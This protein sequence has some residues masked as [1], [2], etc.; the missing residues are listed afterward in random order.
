M[1]IVDVWN[2][3]EKDFF[4]KGVFVY[5]MIEKIYDGE[6]KGLFL[7]CLNLIVLNLNVNFVKKV[8]EKFEF[9]VVVDMFELEMVKLVNLILL[10][11]F[12]L[13]DEGIMINV[14]GRVIL[15]EVS[16]LCGGE[17]KYDWEILCEIVKVLGKEE[18]FLFLLV[19]EIFNE[20]WIVSKGGIVDYSGIM[21]EWLWEEK[22]I[23]WLCRSL[24]DKGI[25]CLF[26]MCFV[27]SD[28]K[29]MM[30]FVLN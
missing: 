4:R 23:L 13:E 5:E 20:L 9:L 12:Y 3:E 18:Y 2:I 10:V 7:M 25:E 11:F 14:E 6:I 22:G 1:Y 27:Y 28:G 8:F 24:I 21:Y 19:E 17:I 15:C 29:V 30:V 16:F 26:E